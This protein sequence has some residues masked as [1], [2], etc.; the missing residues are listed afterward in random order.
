MHLH[1][2]PEQPARQPESRPARLVDGDHSFD[3]STDRPGS[4]TVDFNGRQQRLGRWRNGLLRLDPRQAWNLCRQD[5]TGVAQ[6]DREHERTAVVEGDRIR[7][8]N[9]LPCHDHDPPKIAHR[10]R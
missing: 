5:P 8:R 1:T 7:I 9:R 4:I 3:R 10:R 2:P 6:F